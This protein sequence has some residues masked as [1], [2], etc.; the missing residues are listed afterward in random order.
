[1]R[2]VPAFCALFL[3][4]CDRAV[5][6][7]S[8]PGLEDAPAN[9]YCVVEW[10]ADAPRV[11]LAALERLPLGG[12]E[13]VFDAEAGH[14]VLLA[15][16]DRRAERAVAAMARLS[17]DAARG[18]ALEAR[19]RGPWRVERDVKGMHVE[20]QPWPASHEALAARLDG[21]AWFTTLTASMT[22][23]LAFEDEST[24]GAGFEPADAGG[25]RLAIDLAEAR[26]MWS[27]SAARGFESILTRIPGLTS[28]RSL[29]V[30]ARPEPSTGKNERRLRFDATTVLARTPV[31]IARALALEAAPLRFEQAFERLR[32]KDDAPVAYAVLRLDP[33]AIIDGLAAMLT[34]GSGLGIDVNPIE[35][36]K[37]LRLGRLLS[38]ELWQALDPEW[39]IYARRSQRALDY[40]MVARM[41]DRA[42]VLEAVKDMSGEAA[43]ELPGAEKILVF[44]RRVFGK[45]LLCYVGSEVVVVATNGMAATAEELVR[46]SQENATAPPRNGAIVCD[47]GALGEGFFNSTAFEA[48]L[49][50]TSTGLALRGVID[51]RGR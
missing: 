32:A 23:A 9:A 41:L 33:L 25:L 5:V 11:L 48:V 35:V 15:P 3:A 1:M 29:A 26:S 22:E 8:L 30:A 36:L 47:R 45:A 31:G 4:A 51:S 43:R 44:E 28:F 2:A 38:R 12:V 20:P 7:P 49:R 19:L 18:E 40:C 37:S 42:L 50:R 34:L 46:T 17:I 6:P 21:Q 14:F 13:A 10:D 24:K 16:L 27:G 39:G